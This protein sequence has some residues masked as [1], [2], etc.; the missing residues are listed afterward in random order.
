MSASAT[1]VLGAKGD[2]HWLVIDK[3]ELTDQAQYSV[4][5]DGKQSKGAVKVI[6]TYHVS[7]L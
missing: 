5:V 2:K 6:G 3:A 7:Y 4:K 1:L